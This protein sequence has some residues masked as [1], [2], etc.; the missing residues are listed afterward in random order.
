MNLRAFSLISVIMVSGF[1]G[2]SCADAED[3]EIT[4]TYREDPTGEIPVQRGTETN[5]QPVP[6]G[7]PIDTV[8]EDIPDSPPVEQ[9]CVADER[10]VNT[11]PTLIF[12]T[13]VGGTREKDRYSCRPETNESGPE[14]MYRIEMPEAGFL[15]VQVMTQDVDTDIDVHLL[16]ENDAADCMDR[17]DNTAGAYLE[18][19]T[20]WI[21]ADTWTN[22]EGREFAGAFELSINVVTVE[23]LVGFNINRPTATDALT[24]FSTAWQRQNTKRFEYTITDFSMSSRLHRQWIVQM[25]TGQLLYNLTV[26]HGRGSIAGDDIAMASVFSNVPESHQSSLGLVKTAEVYVGD[27]GYSLRLDG[28]EPDF[29]SN[30]RDRFIVVHPWYGNEP[31]RVEADGWVVPSWGCAT[32]DPAVSRAVIDT[33]SRGSLMF[34]WY[35]EPTWLGHSTYL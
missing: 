20:Y 15:A 7:A 6:V 26:G 14:R 1:L 24:A 3:P 9:P 22:E 5:P 10:C 31:E 29:N 23:N 34:F 11:F 16:L 30:I 27:Y 32:L 35:P 28:L 18:A 17:G 12:D 2:W 25:A 21:A 4:E 13:T 33:I 19:G 8:S